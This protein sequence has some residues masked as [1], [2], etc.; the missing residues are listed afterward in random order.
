MTAD[1]LTIGVDAAPLPGSEALRCSLATIGTTPVVLAQWD[2]SRHGG[3]F[4]V[5]DATGFVAAV[6]TAIKRRLPLVTVMRSGGTR[7]PEGMRALVG[8]PRSAIAL[9]DL[10]AAGLPHITVADHPT[11]GGV[12][13]AVGSGADIRIGVAEALVGFSGPRVVSAMTGRPLP[14][15]ASTTESA[16]DAGLVDVIATPQTVPGL[17]A[18]AL[19]ALGPDDAAPVTA[20]AMAQPPT[21]DGDGQVIA[22]HVEARLSGSEL[23]AGLLTKPVP[24]SGGDPTVSAAIGRIAGRRAVVVALAAKRA[25]MPGPKGFDLLRRAAQLAGSFDLSLVVLVDTPGADPHTESLGLVPAIAAALMAVLDCSAP[26]ISLV[27]GEG[28]SGGALAG[29]V[30]DVVGVSRYGW[31]AALGPEGAAAALRLD[32]AE[33]SR[34]M[35]ITPAELLSDG[36]AD[37]YVEPAT[38]LAWVAGAIDRLRG[39]PTADRLGRRR[40]RWSSP[41]PGMTE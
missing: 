8:I 5:D 6:H 9:A 37:S 41:L 27:H 35:R 18:D 22:S 15:G 3:S 21:L 17:V 7:L 31:F 19:A 24:L 40:T 1:G 13:V 33:A 14:S 16:Y 20:P 10:R 38:E 34:L 23:A 32:A 30:T 4:G 39:E 25:A 26:T 29:A 11:T 2:F 36:F 28:G 12:W